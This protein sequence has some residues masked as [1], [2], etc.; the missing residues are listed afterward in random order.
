[1]V[2]IW[3]A[4]CNEKLSERVPSIGA[5]NFRRALATGEAS[6]YGDCEL[7]IFIGTRNDYDSLLEVAETV[8]RAG[9]GWIRSSK[10]NDAKPVEYSSMSRVLSEI[11]WFSDSAERRIL[12]RRERGRVLRSFVFRNDGN[13]K[14][15][16]AETE[17]FYYVICFATS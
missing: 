3:I 12:P 16:A 11:G 13:F 5:R 8:L 2:H 1:M 14:L 15:F 9:G 10:M 17:G 6:F 4:A 7:D